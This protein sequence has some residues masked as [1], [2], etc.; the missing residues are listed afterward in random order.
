LLLVIC[1][2]LLMAQAPVDSTN[3]NID[4]SGQKDLLDIGNKLFKLKPRRYSKKYEKQ[5]YFSI[6]PLS[7]NV[8]GTNNV[9]V[10]STTAGFYLGPR[11]TT[12]IS[13]VTFA[14]YFNFKGRY[15]LP[16][17]SSIWFVD[18]KYNEEGDTRFLVYPK[19]G[20]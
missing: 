1:P 15:G 10:T 13:T 4:T 7:T 9:L 2:A 18:N 14:P 8:A 12:Y 5:V 6:L 3:I 19:R 16:I 11:T 20:R 17:H